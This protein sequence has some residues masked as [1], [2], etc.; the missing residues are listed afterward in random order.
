MNIGNRIRRVIDNFDNIS[1]E[2]VAVTNIMGKDWTVNKSYADAFI[3]EDPINEYRLHVK[4]FYDESDQISK[5]DLTFD[6]NNDSNTIVT[7]RFD[8][9]DYP[10][11][12]TF[13]QTLLIRLMQ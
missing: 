3:L 8:L 11:L 10:L 12:K 4:L 5:I 2:K 13:V 1:V 7:Y 9:L 6:D